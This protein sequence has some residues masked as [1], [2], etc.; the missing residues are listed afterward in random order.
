MNDDVLS[1]LARE[2]HDLTE[3]RCRLGT[4][5]ADPEPV[6]LVQLEPGAPIDSATLHAHLK[7]L[8]LQ[9]GWSTRYVIVGGSPAEFRPRK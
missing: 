7:A 3:G 5:A 9:Q 1:Q 8:C 4:H 6:L 2:A